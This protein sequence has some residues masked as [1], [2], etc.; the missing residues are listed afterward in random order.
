VD[1][2]TRQSRSM[3]YAPEPLACSLRLKIIIGSVVQHSPIIPDG[4]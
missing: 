1:S 2:L 3:Q 4:N